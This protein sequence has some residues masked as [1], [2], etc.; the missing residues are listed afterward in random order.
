[1]EVKSFDDEI[2]KIN[3]KFSGDKGNNPMIFLTE[4]I[5]KLSEETNEKI[6]KLFKGKDI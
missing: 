1:M 5:K 2:N 3:N 6:L 4:F